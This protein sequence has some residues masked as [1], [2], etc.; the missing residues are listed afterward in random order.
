MSDDPVRTVIVSDEG[1]LAFQEYLVARR[2]QPP[3]HAVEHDGL[4]EA[5]PAPDVLPALRS[6]DLVILAPSSPVASVAPILGLPGVRPAL[7]GARVVA[8]TPVVSGQPPAT[9]PEQSRAKVRSAFMAAAGLDHSATAVAGLYADIADTFVLDHRDAPEA[10]GI[11]ALGIGVLTADT[12]ATGDGRVRL[13]EAVL[14]LA[15]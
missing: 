11:R 3:V 15:G 4:A 14:A 9:P 1:R 8:I 12:L 6:A 10:D 2:A 13:A 5:Q 7:A